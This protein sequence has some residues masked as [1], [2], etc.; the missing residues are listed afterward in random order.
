MNQNQLFQPPFFALGQLTQEDPYS[1][2]YYQKTGY[3]A[4]TNFFTERSA[5][6]QR[7][8][9]LETGNEWGMKAAMVGTSIGAAIG[10]MAGAFWGRGWG[11]AGATLIGAFVGGTTLGVGSNFVGEQLGREAGK[12]LAILDD[13]GDGTQ[14]ADG[15]YLRNQM[16][17]EF[18]QSVNRKA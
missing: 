18:M 2:K 13:F 15:G 12:R 10:A 4:P 14:V 8:T 3:I 7:H 1:R 9:E 17:A 16:E 6:A 5:L 11:K